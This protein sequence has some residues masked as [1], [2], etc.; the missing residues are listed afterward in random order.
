MIVTELKMNKFGVVDFDNSEVVAT[1]KIEIGLTASDVDNIMVTAIEG[2]I[3]YWARLENDTDEWKD[4]PENISSAQWATHLL[5]Q[6]KFVLFS[7]SE[8]FDE[9]DP[10]YVHPPLTLEGLAK[11][12]ALNHKKRPWDS[13]IEN[14][15]AT[16]CDC[17]VQYAIFG[18]LVYG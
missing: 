9:S 6:G 10:D 16:T 7:D 4:K 5:L 18:E 12:Y 11:G 14:G 15:D 3:G 8:I 13:S 2:G 1:A 17:I